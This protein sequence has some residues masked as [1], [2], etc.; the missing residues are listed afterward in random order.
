MS[1][2]K[3]KKLITGNLA[4]NCYLVYDEKEEDLVIIDP[5]DDA[6]YIISQIRDI[7]IAPSRIIATH[8]HFDHL[9]AA[10]A[11]KLAFNI[12]FLMH[13]K[14]LFLL[15][16][17][18]SSAKYFL[19][20]D[21]DPAPQVDEYITEGDEIMIGKTTLKVIESPGHSP[22]GVV[23]YDKKSE[24]AF[25]G[26]TIFEK[27]VVGR[28]DFVYAKQADLDKSIQK[29]LKLPDSTKILPGHGGA[30]TIKEI[31]KYLAKV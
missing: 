31:K 27:G 12:P 29:I 17:L 5:G 14:D 21:V 18:Q 26:D 8:G 1:A 11:I 22:G 9:L 28:T 3:V 24:T 23:L 19:G 16:R 6:E 20:L 4:T 10:T 7:E 13:K 2:L 25:V 30:T 15:D